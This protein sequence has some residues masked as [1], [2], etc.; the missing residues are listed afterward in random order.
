MAFTTTTS[1]LEP[2][3]PC[4]QAYLGSSNARRML[5]RAQLSRKT[6]GSGSD[7][8]IF[9][10]HEEASA[11]D[12]LATP[13]HAPDESPA[14]PPRTGYSVQCYATHIEDEARRKETV[15]AE[16]EVMGL[17]NSINV[18]RRVEGSLPLKLKPLLCKHAQEQAD[19]LFAEEN[20][21][22][23]PSP[24]S[25]PLPAYV[26]NVTIHE[27]RSGRRR[28]TLISPPAIGALAC[29]EMWYGGKYRAHLYAV[30]EASSSGASG[31]SGGSIASE[32][33]PVHQEDCP[34][35]LRMVFETMVDEGWTCVGI[36]RG[37]DGRGRWVVE[38]GE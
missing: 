16:K 13:F 37:G 34:C 7:D 11:Q 38:L 30:R 17:L 21:S 4:Q 19:T 32:E 6:T 10:L 25:A 3:R 5:K 31:S 12:P 1:P 35:R 18:S 2:L 23:P 20:C 36:G 15:A 14:S 24:G 28:A 22:I 9:A 33:G 26:P 27:S 29:G 8:P